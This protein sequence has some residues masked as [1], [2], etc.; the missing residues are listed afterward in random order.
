MD[1]FKVMV[2]GAGLQGAAATSILSRDPEVSEI[3]LGD[4]NIKLAY[5]VK[6]KIKSEKIMPIKLDASKEADVVEKGKN[7]DLI[8]N[9][10]LPRFNLNIMKA[11]LEIDS[12][13]VDAACGPDYNL[14][15]IDYL[16]ESQ[17]S[18]DKDFKDHDLTALIS[19]GFTPG[20]SNVIAK[21]LV[22]PLKK[23]EYIKFRICGKLIGYEAPDIL[24]PIADYAE[25]L[26]PTWSPEVSFLYRATNAVVFDNGKWKRLPPSSGLEE[27]EFP[28]PVGKCLNALVDHEEPV[29]FPRFIDKP[30]NYVDYKNPP[31][32]IA[33]SL[34][35]LGFADNVPIKIGDKEIVPRDVLLKLLKQPVNMFLNENEEILSDEKL[36][37]YHGILIVE[38]YGEDSNG[39]V[40]Y[41]GFFTVYSP[42]PTAEERLSLYRKLGTTHI[43]VALPSVVSSKM[44]LKNQS[45]KGV[46]APETLNPKVFFKLMKEYGYPVNLQVQSTRKLEL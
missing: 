5:D 25:I 14:N 23:I 42:P 3:I 40:K 4:I 35:K 39:P 1:D 21:Y 37:Y 16:V 29:T 33:W 24:Q 43:L 32:L 12:H 19:S 36:P 2:I 11:A 30:I 10:S 20:L 26:S 31:D 34:I 6:E 38:A 17:L 27:Y 18:L 28:N 8:I 15:P 44:I 46:I 22:E 13:Y 41:K 45:S 7:I 9:M